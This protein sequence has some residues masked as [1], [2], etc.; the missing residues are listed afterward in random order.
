MSEATAAATP[1]ATQTATAQVIPPG[2]WKV[3]PV[4]S[5]V[6]FH[7]KH[8]GIATVKGQFKQFEGTLVSDPDGVVAYGTVDTASVD[9]R[10][11]QRD[12]HLRSPDFFEVDKYPQIT[13]RSS[14][15]RATGEDEF[16]IVADLTI[17]GVTRQVTLGATLEGVEPEDHQGNTR[18]GISATTQINRSDFEMRFNAALGSGNVVVSDKVKI[19]VEVSAVKQA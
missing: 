5:S 14:E 13:F 7:V 2:T 6:E 17:H 18:V 19:L 11:P 8:L 4:H 15:I 12:E 10:E 9:T 1:T 16:E 3:D